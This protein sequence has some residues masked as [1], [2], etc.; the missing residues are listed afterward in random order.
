MTKQY[1]TEYTEDYVLDIINMAVGSWA[2]E[3][4][5]ANQDHS[6]MYAQRYKENMDTLIEAIYDRLLS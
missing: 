1:M 5:E 3:E 4:V 2:Q 6:D